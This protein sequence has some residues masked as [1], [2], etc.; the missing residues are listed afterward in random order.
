FVMHEDRYAERPGFQVRVD[1]FARKRQ[2]GLRG[3]CLAIS[4]LRLAAGAE[5]VR[6]PTEMKSG[7]AAAISLTLASVTP[8][9]TSITARPLII[10]TAFRIAGTS[11]LS[12]RRMSA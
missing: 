5:W 2:I 10:S 11:M 6:A 3:H 9:E 12:K 1:G 8:P 7:P 4:M